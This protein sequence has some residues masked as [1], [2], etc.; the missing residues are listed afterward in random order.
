M[1]Q[2][3]SVYYRIQQNIL[4]LAIKRIQAIQKLREIDIDILE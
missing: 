4:Y 3:E 2:L 1:F